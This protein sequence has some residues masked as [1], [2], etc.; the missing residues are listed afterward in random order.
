MKRKI[1]IAGS[2]FSGPGIIEIIC[3]KCSFE[4]NVRIYDYFKCLGTTIKMD[5]KSSTHHFGCLKSG[6]LQLRKAK[7]TT[8][9]TGRK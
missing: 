8:S 9:I 2:S 4:P 5:K 7:Q 6:N 3:S 1:K